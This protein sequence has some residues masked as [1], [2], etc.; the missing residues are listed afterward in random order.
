MLYSS[1]LESDSEN[2]NQ[3]TELK[4][5]LIGASGVGKTS[6][7]ERFVKNF[8]NEKQRKT[9]GSTFLSKVCVVNEKSYYLNIWDTAGEER[10]HSLVKL[11]YRDTN[12]AILCFDITKQS[13]FRDLDHWYQELQN[14]APRNVILMIVGNKTDLEEEREV[15]EK[16]IKDWA[17]NRNC[18][19]IE[20]SAKTGS[21][22]NNLFENVC[23]IFS[24]KFDKIE[25]F[26]S[27]E[28]LPIRKKTIVIGSNKQ[29]Q[30]RQKKLKQ[31]KK[32][33]C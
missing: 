13:S 33:C 24:E 26:L 11:Y 14:S 23:K 15:Q 28:N 31:E 32:K 16:E 29:Q 1:D 3:Q 2:S 30:N 25:N 27:E 19:Y 12:I 8:F 7:V 18:S 10:F 17:L 5:V 21:N 6:I 22:I 9:I 20:T 4:I